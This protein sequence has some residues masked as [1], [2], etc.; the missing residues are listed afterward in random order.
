MDLEIVSVENKGEIDSERLV[1]KA[2]ADDVSTWDYAVLDNTYGKEDDV[3]NKNRHVFYFD[4]ESPYVTLDKGEVIYLY[5]KRGKY[6]KKEVSGVLH[7]YFYWCL[8]KSIWNKDGDE[9]TLINVSE[10]KSK[11]V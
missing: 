2:K 6:Q 8:G 1:L 10:K 5:T 3:S 9:V 4:D 11:S 7:H